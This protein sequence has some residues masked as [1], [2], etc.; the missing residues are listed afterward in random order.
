MT[1]ELAEFALLALGVAV[2]VFTIV[3][4]APELR[5][6]KLRD[7]VWRAWHADFL[8]RGPDPKPPRYN[9]DTI[10][11]TLIDDE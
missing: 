10:P 9:F 8:R 7:T 1:P 11:P 6:R 4:V 2:I 3:F 5:K